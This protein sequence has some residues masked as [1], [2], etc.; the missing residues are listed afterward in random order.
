MDAGIDLEKVEEAV[1]VKVEEEN[2]ST[3]EELYSLSKGFERRNKGYIHN[4]YLPHVAA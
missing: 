2:R 4:A 1:R 3:F